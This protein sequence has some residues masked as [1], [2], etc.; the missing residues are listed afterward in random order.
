MV[1]NNWRGMWGDSSGT[2][3]AVNRPLSSTEEFH[4][5]L[6]LCFAELAFPR[7]PTSGGVHPTQEAKA[8]GK[9]KGR[10]VAQGLPGQISGR[11]VVRIPVKVIRKCRRCRHLTNGRILV[12]H[13]AL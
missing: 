5:A 9:G 13:A 4:A 2:V 3:V 7:F 6:W 11:L 12:S 10:L 1:N 8:K